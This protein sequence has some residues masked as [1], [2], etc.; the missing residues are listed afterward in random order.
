[1]D[2]LK[3]LELKQATFIPGGLMDSS[4][5]TTEWITETAKKLDMSLTLAPTS[6]TLEYGFLV[7]H[8]GVQYNFFYRDLLLEERK[9]K[10][11]EFMQVL[12]S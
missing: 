5:F 1:M 12:F 10:G 11:R 8:E 9:N 2:I 4:I 3:T 7:E 6:K